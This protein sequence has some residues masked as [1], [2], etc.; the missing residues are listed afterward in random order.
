MWKPF[1]DEIG[2]NVKRFWVPSTDLPATWP[3]AAN[4]GEGSILYLVN[5][6]TD[7]VTGIRQFFGGKWNKLGA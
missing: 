5:T 4:C 3:T 2:T 1:G 6:A 7:E